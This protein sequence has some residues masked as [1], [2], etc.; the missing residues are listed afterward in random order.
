MERFFHLG[1]RATNGSSLTHGATVS[2]T[3][4]DIFYLVAA[5]A[6]MPTSGHARGH[7][8]LMGLM[9]LTVLYQ[10]WY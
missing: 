2:K 5:T 7:S 1:E 8:R 10:S 6:S 9:G 4:A 3:H